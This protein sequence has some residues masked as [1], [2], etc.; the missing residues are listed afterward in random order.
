MTREE[1]E[2]ILLLNYELD[3]RRHKE[4]F[5]EFFKDAWKAVDPYTT[6]QE[7]WHIKYQCFIAQQALEGIINNTPS[8]HSTILI[9]VP[10]RSL[11]SWVFNIA[12]PVY[13]WIHNPSLPMITSSYSLDLGLGFSRKSQQIITS[14]W[15]QRRYSD[16]VKIGLSEG[17]REAVGETETSAGGIRFV[18]STESTVVGK[19]MLLGVIDD[20]LKPVE[21]TQQKSLEKNIAFF[22]ESID[23]RR[24]NPITSVIFV[25]MQRLAENDLSGYLSTTYIDDKKFLHINLPAIQ[26]G[27]EKVPYLDEF[28]QKHPEEQDNIY[29]NGYLFGDRFDED[30]IAK[31]QKKGTIFWNTQY[32]QNPL[33]TDGLLFKRDWFSKISLDEYLRLERSYNLKRSFITDTAYTDKAKNDPTAILTYSVHDG[34]TYIINAQ[35]EHID[36]ANLPKFIESYVIRNG[37]DKRKSVITIE[38]KGSGS[39]V[40]SLLKKLT[41]LN[42]IP[43][44]YPASAR[45][46]INMSKDIRAE[47]IVPMVESGK[48]VLVD[49]A[50]N[51]QLIQQMTTF[52]LSRHDDLVDTTVMCLLRS[53]YI[54]QHYKK[55]ALKRRA[56]QTP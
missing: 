48:L 36:S 53:H 34:I 50:W 14:N 44:K 56:N 15:F 38:P 25:I 42:V 20:P 41:D 6:L 9:N 46:N 12:L 47:S 4:S 51:E 8:K 54:D 16:I 11:K 33:P 55:F 32:Q 27:S 37:Y 45:V 39:V 13:A 3:R 52:P 23:T 17:G 19:G 40:I 26:D 21:A 29:K 35:T 1:Q 28:L 2:R 5:Y 22:N 30:F 7:N 18:A 43:Y 24:N 31:Q 10:P 49:G